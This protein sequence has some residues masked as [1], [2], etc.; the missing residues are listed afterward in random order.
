MGAHCSHELGDDG[1]N[2]QMREYAD[3][4]VHRLNANDPNLVELHLPNFGIGDQ[5]TS[6]VRH[7]PI[8]YQAIASGEHPEMN[9]VLLPG[10]SLH[11]P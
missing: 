6:E 11:V 3:I 5:E 10:D 4:A 9:L 7:I 8:A 2:E 1:L